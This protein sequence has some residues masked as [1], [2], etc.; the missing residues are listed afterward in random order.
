MRG[1]KTQ[2]GHSFLRFFQIVQN[3]AQR[4]NAVFFLECGEGNE[5]FA[6]DIEGEDLRGWLIPEEQADL[7]EALWEAGTPGDE[8]ADCIVWALWKSPSNT[9]SITF[10][11]Y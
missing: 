6:D 1:L 2:E 11:N 4:R 10:R 5:Y 3:E 7:F 9:L 8:W